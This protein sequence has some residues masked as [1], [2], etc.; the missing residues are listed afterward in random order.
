MALAFFATL[1]VGLFLLVTSILHSTLNPDHTLYWHGLPWFAHTDHWHIFL[2]THQFFDSLFRPQASHTIFSRLPSLFPDLFLASIVQSTFHPVLTQHSIVAFLIL[3]II[4]ISTIVIVYSSLFTRQLS[5]SLL[6][7]LLSLSFLHR[8]LPFT[9]YIYL[10]IHHGGNVF[11]TFAALTLYLNIYR[12]TSQKRS[13][14][15][16][17]NA[18]LLY[19]L[20]SLA[21]FSNKLF[22]F[23]ALIPILCCPSFPL[24]RRN[25][26]PRYQKTIT[27]I[28]LFVVALSF[29][30]S[31]PL[32]QGRDDLRVTTSSLIPHLFHTFTTSSAILPLLIILFFDLVLLFCLKTLHRQEYRS[33]DPLLW[34]TS[35]I[36]FLSAV[37][38]TSAGLMISVANNT[39][40]ISRYLLSPI[41]LSVVLTSVLLLRL[42]HTLFKS[43]PIFIQFSFLILLIFCLFPSPLHPNNFKPSSQ[44]LTKEMALIDL[45]KSE[46]PISPFGFATSPPWHATTLTALSDSSLTIREVSSDGNPLFWHLW[47]GS[48]V[49]DQGYLRLLSGKALVERDILPFSFVVTGPEESS[50]IKPFFGSP[51]RSIYCQN[52]G[53]NCLHYYNEPSS[54]MN[55]TAIFINTYG[56]RPK[57]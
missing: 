25:R 45:I 9:N 55:N 32:T 6:V 47:K 44:L 30:I 46:P 43:K 16:S 28:G 11:N 1:L 41:A 52:V 26:L 27:V 54:L 12:F 29:T 23:S 4:A 20:F 50:L 42:L 39:Y 3:N 8:A 24:S 35:V 7:A 51:S 19:V 17:L 2:Q 57:T 22:I 53:Y 48:F 34:R 40:D 38:T 31:L 10:P 15:A 49:N 36:T 37:L 13:I 56:L 21:T 33:L 14:L 18:A 5:T